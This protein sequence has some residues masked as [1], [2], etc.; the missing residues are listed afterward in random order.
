M[1]LKRKISLMALGTIVSTSMLPGCSSNQINNKS[2]GSRELLQNKDARLAITMAVNKEEIINVILNNGSD[3]VNYYTPQGLAI[4]NEGK[5]YR[6]IT[7]D[8]GKEYDLKKAKIHWDRAKDDLGFKNV[9]IEIL[10]SEAE[11]S[12]RVGEF[13]QNQLQNNLDG[14]IVELKQVPFK[15][16]QQLESEG[17]YDLVYSS[18]VSDYLDPLTFLETF[19]SNGKFGK[20]SGYDSKE[21]NDLIEEGKNATTIDASWDKYAKA[22]EILLNDAFIMPLFQSSSVYIKKTYVDGITIIPY[23]AKYAYKWAS[24]NGKDEL[25]LTSSSDIPSLDMSRATDSLSFSAANNVMEGFARV[26]NDGNIV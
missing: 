17:D 15:Q 7:G 12:K 26:D 14:M 21:Y 10:T 2:I 9:T 6:D 19:T 24:V 11:S 25:N 3:P 16:K 20:N 22:E 1:T 5:D 23:G 8:M 4:N 18:W 13:F